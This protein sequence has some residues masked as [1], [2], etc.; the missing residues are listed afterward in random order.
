MIIIWKAEYEGQDIRGD[1][2]KLEEIHRRI[3]ERVG[4]SV[5]GPYFPQD[6]SVAYIF[7]AEKY[8]WLNQ[9]G[10]IWFPEVAKAKLRFTPVKYE[11][12]VTPEEF[13][14]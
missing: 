14:G 5:D 6:A 2:S 7:H 8:E 9:A 13:F 11:V 3:V 10:R 4:G 12:C 1:L